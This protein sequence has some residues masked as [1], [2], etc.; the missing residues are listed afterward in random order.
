M[1]AEDAPASTVVVVMPEGGVV[2][3]GLKFE[4]ASRP[5]SMVQRVLDAGRLRCC[6][7]GA[8]RLSQPTVKSLA[9]AHTV[10]RAHST[11]ETLTLDKFELEMGPLQSNQQANS[12]RP[13]SHQHF[14]HTPPSS[15]RVS[16]H[17]R[18][19]SFYH[20]VAERSDHALG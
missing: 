13:A 3:N 12:T 16:A 17:T 15:W 2:S 9:H 11:D 20:C 14:T 1:V 5:S 19:H 18:G 10:S 7:C 4:A 6:E 8:A